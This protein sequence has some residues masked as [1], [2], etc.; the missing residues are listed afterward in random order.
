MYEIPVVRLS[1]VRESGGPAMSVR[2]PVRT[3]DQA[4]EI[5]RSYLGDPDRE[6]FVVLLLDVR[7]RPIGVHTV[8]IGSLTASLVHPR[9]VFK[10]A[11]CASAA[12]I[13]AGHNHP[14]GEPDPS[15]DDYTITRRLVEG[16]SLL[17]IRV[18]D[19]VILGDGRSFS[20]ADN[21]ELPAPDTKWI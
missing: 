11:I 21:G 7:N 16:G 12:A 3:S 13:I 6:H 4:A 15:K 10:A 14:S 17:G 18:L 5:L 9:E 2:L 19:H 8:S 20:F 1:L